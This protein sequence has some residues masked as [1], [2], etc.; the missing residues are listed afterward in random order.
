MGILRKSMKNCIFCKSNDVQSIQKIVKSDIVDLYQKEL[1]IDILSEL[2]ENEVVEAMECATCGL[3][4]FDPKAIGSGD[5]YEKL[6]MLEGDYYSNDRPEFAM[7]MKYINSQDSVLEVGSGSAFFARKLNVKNYVG[8]EY[9]D[10]AILKAKE[11]NIDLVKESIEIYSLKN[12]EAF[13]VVCSFHVL[14]HVSNPEAFLESSINGLVKGGKLIVAVPCADS[15]FTKNV[16]HVLNMPPHHIT[17]WKIDTL[18][19]VAKKFNLNV[20][21]VNVDTVENRA[22]YFELKYAFLI[23]RLVFSRRTILN[24]SKY[25][26]LIL[27]IIKKLNRKLGLYKLENNKAYF[28]KNMLIVFEK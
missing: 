1:G 24:K 20:L 8:L 25:Y 15:Y 26:D 18:K 28:G 17:R 2:S 21:D 19:Y 16:N 11:A 14:E 9:N 10:E 23:N 12:K 4:F 22:S 27:K 3:I 7:A 13:D 6:Q 5:F